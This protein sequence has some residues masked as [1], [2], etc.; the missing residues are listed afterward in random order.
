MLNWM[1][2]RQKSKDDG[3]LDDKSAAKLRDL[4]ETVRSIAPD[5]FGA[6]EQ[7]NSRATRIPRK[8]DSD[9]QLAQ[10]G[11][12]YAARL[13]ADLA[14]D[15]E[16]EDGQ[17][18]FDSDVRMDVAR[19]LRRHL[20]DLSPSERLDMVEE[21]VTAIGNMADCYRPQVIALIEQE[22]SHTPYMTRQAAMRLRQDI[23]AIG[24]VSL[25]EYVEL[26]SDADFL[27]ILRGRGEFVQ[28]AAEKL[29]AEQEAAAQARLARDRS[30]KGGLLNRLLSSDDAPRNVVA[31]TPK[32]GSRKEA[33]SKTPHDE[34]ADGR[35]KISRQAQRRVAH[36]ILAS[37]FDTLVERGRMRAEVA[38]AMRQ[39]VRQR[40]EKAKFESRIVSRTAPVPVEHE[41]DD[42]MHDDAGEQGGPVEPVTI[43]HYILDALSRNEDA[44]VVQSLA[45]YAQMPA[46][47]VSKILDSGS[48]RAITALAWRAGMSAP[49]AVVL[50]MSAA[51]PEDSIERPAAGGRY[52]MASTDMDWYIDFFN[53]LQPSGPRG[54]A[55]GTTA[56]ASPHGSEKSGRTRRLPDERPQGP[57]GE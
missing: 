50:Q 38:R 6:T 42:V 47:I 27:D 8:K 40:I 56:A 15:D 5:E 19:R 3:A 52:A 13:S 34:M 17:P 21:F 53:E 11:L 10:S 24:R 20:N 37:L 23:A 36:F 44:L 29:E 45:H 57:K 26:L 49:S 16:D 9:G 43:D 51:I 4:A 28:T 18:D 39:S 46:A 14:D 55:A 54:R 33:A 7:A 30:E 35:N 1:F 22:L 41:F 12:D 25:G 2:N 48:A 32:F 31:L